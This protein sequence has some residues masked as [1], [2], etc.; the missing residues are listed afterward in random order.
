M[1]VGP[2]GLVI[3][4]GG[5]LCPKPVANSVHKQLNIQVGVVHLYTVAMA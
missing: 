5:F 3:M 1:T 2:G 4:A